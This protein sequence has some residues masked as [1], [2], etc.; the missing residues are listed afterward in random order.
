MRRDVIKKHIDKK[1]LT[2][3]QRLGADGMRQELSEIC[4]KYL[5]NIVEAPSPS[6]VTI[7]GIENIKDV[8]SRYLSLYVFYAQQRIIDLYKV[9]N[10]ELYG[11]SF[12]KKFKALLFKEK[13]E[14]GKTT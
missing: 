3:I 12:H 11:W 8:R 1:I 5:K 13:L 9:E 7:E 6:P 2:D 14:G 4:N 10:S